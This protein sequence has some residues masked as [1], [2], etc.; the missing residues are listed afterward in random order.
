M[1]FLS[2]GR[3]GGGFVTNSRGD[4]MIMSLVMVVMF[5]VIFM[6]LAGLTGRQHRETVLQAHDELAFQMAE[7]GLNYARWRLAHD[8]DDF[9]SVS[10][11]VEDQFAGIIGTYEVTFEEPQPGSTTVIITSVGTTESQPSREITLRARY[12]IPSLAR[13]ASITND[14]V[15]YGGEIHGYVHSNGGIRM[16]GDSDSLMTSEQ[17][18]YTCQPHHGCSYEDRPGIWGTGTTQELWEFPVTRIDYNSLTLDLIDMQD[19]A[20]EADTYYGDSG[21][22][23]YHLVFNDNNTYS[24]YRV[25]SKSW[26]RWSYASDTGWEYTSHDIGSESF[27]ETEDVP[28]NGIL[29]FEDH[30]WVEGD[31]RDRVTIAAG[32]LPDQPNDRVDIIINGDIDY[33]GVEDGTRAFGAIAQRN[34]LIPYAGADDNL[35]LDGA[36]IAQN[37]RFGRRYYDSGTHRLKTSMN[38]FGMIASNL[39]PVTAWVSG[40]TVVSGYQTGVSNYDPNLLYSPP[41]YFPT[42]GQYEFISWEE[43]EE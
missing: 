31:I 42:S 28:S 3:F 30:V 13:Y 29:Y 38:R 17:E 7:A 22:Y 8:G 9:T 41:P 27:I 26:Y 20:G 39:V 40:S 14:D 34:V 33:G 32:V 6:A 19:A 18:E 15:W 36:F 5:V 11:T 21:G 4:I 23:G 24:L 16:D 2:G 12:G 1:K 37:G 43:V 35:E 10:D 25:N